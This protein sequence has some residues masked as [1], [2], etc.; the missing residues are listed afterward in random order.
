MRRSLAP[1]QKHK[2]LENKSAGTGSGRTN[3]TA[4]ANDD[5]M[6]TIQRMPLFGFLE[7]PKSLSQQFKVPTG[8]VLTEK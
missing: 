6:V 3:P 1:S 8:C 4:N 7:I 5:D 2:L